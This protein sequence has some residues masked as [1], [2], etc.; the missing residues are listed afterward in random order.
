MGIAIIVDYD[1]N[2]CHILHGHAELNYY[3]SMTSEFKQGAFCQEFGHL[4]GLDHSDTGDCMGLGYYSSTN[5]YTGPHNWDDIYY[6]YV[7]HYY[8]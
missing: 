5:Y 4:L 7:N 3:Y 6:K 2:K 8:H 1:W